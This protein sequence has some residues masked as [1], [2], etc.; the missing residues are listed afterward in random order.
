[1]IKKLFFAVVLI[2]LTFSCGK[3]GDPI[4]NSE[5]QNVKNTKIFVVS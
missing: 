4:Y 1:M 3:K 5:R 2:S